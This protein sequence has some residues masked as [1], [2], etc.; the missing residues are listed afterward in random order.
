MTLIARK[1]TSENLFSSQVNY[2][3]DIILEVLIIVNIGYQKTKSQ[4]NEEAIINSTISKCS[5]LDHM[6]Q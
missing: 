4:L 6:L 5:K 3:V 1:D 2:K